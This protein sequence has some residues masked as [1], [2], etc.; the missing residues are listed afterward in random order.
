MHLGVLLACS[1]D[2]PRTFL[3]RFGELSGQSGLALGCPLDVFGSYWGCFLAVC[4][5]KSIETQLQAPIS[6]VFS[7]FF[8][9][10]THR[11]LV[12]YFLLSAIVLASVQ[13]FFLQ[14]TDVAQQES[15]QIN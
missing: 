3:T 11:F 12:W 10:F 5:R 6:A 1:W 4:A 2:A 15:T 13:S 14:E 7:R 8:D 9:R